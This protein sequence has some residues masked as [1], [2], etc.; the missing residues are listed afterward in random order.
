MRAGVSSTETAQVVLDNGNTNVQTNDKAR[1]EGNNELEANSSSESTVPDGGWGWM[2][3]LGSFVVHII[4]FGIAYSFGVFVEYFIQYFQCS[5]SE[6]G[7]LGSLIIGVTWIVG[8]VNLHLI[9]DKIIMNIQGGSK[10]VS[11]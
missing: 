9:C 7:G 2:V 8:N 4:I 11:C 3:V 5:K 6:I 1:L 10:K